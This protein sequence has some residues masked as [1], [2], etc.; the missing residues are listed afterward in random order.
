MFSGCFRF[1]WINIDL[2]AVLG[3]AVWFWGGCVY[4]VYLVLVNLWVS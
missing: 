2:W 1:V 4:I 3:L